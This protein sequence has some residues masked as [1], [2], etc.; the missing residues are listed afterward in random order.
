M[1]IQ[2]DLK[3]VKHPTLKDAGTVIDKDTNEPIATYSKERWG[4]TY[5]MAWHPTF[6]ALNP[7]VKDSYEAKALI[8]TGGYREGPEAIAAV[9][10]RVESA[11]D[12]LAKQGFRDRH[13]VVA[14]QE[15]E[16]TI[17]DYHDRK[18]GDHLATR[19]VPSGSGNASLSADF[20]QKHN[21][22]E[23]V[24]SAVNKRLSGLNHATFASRLNDEVKELTK[25][26]HAVGLH[27]FG[28]GRT[29]V[30]HI[31]TTGDEASA[32]HEEVLGGKGYTVNRLSP[33]HFMATSNDGYTTVH[34]VVVG[35]KLH[36]MSTTVGGYSS[37]KLQNT[38]SF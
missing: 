10:G 29:D 18:T 30:Y 22:P 14:R 16:H 36:S 13:H 6:L 27:S 4:K 11:H 20:I 12:Q 1:I 37:K 19:K 28:D 26:K 15:G 9:V 38:N 34:S 24:A 5:N 8:D 2:E 35:D 21:V 17:L 25:K 33:T 7:S 31:G 3:S 32:K 23:D